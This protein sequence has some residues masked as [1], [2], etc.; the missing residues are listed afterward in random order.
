MRMR[1]AFEQK[2]G[3]NKMMVRKVVNE[4]NI[5]MIKRIKKELTLKCD[6]WLEN[7]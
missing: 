4:G 6:D 5:K 3:I 1:S 7:I 2:F